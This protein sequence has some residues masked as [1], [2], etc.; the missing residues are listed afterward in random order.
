MLSKLEAVNLMLDA[1]GEDPVSSLDSGLDDAATAERILDRVSK[2]IQAKGWYA[3]SDEKF[4]FTRNVDNRIPIGD[5]VLR[6]AAVGTTAHYRVVP[7]FLDG[8]RFLYDLDNQTFTFSRDLFCDVV[9][10]Y[11]FEELTHELATYIA[12]KAAAR[13][14]VSE[15][16]SVALSAMIKES[17]A[18]AWAALQDAE[19]DMERTNLFTDNPGLHYATYRYNRKRGT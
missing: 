18:D 11:D 9:W 1:I 15:L 17:L 14:Q 7:R 3:N 2:D 13:Y 16:G 4:E 8:E 10:L 6:I 5:T 19:Q 12:W